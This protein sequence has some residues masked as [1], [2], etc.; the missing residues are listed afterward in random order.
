MNPNEMARRLRHDLIKHLDIPAP[1]APLSDAA[2]QVLARRLFDSGTGMCKTASILGFKLRHDPDWEPI[3]D[4]KL[5]R[6]EALCAKFETN[7]D[8]IVVRLK[9]GKSLTNDEIQQLHDIVAAVEDFETECKRISI[10]DDMPNLEE[11]AFD[12][13]GFG[14]NISKKTEHNSAF[15]IQSSPHDSPSPE[16]LHVLVVDDHLMLI[17]RLQ[18]NV[19]FI[20]RF[21]WATLC[22]RQISC[23]ACNARESCPLRRARNAHEA[24][25]AL[26][27]S[28]RQNR[29]ID[30]ILMDIRFDA[31][32]PEELL[33][34]SE[35]P[36]LQ[37]PERIK[38]LQG[39]IIAR[40]LR[41]FPDFARIPIVLM[42]D[43]SRL[44]DGANSLL[45]NMSGLQFVDDEDSLDAL[46]ARIESIVKLEREVRVEQGY[47]WG[48]SQSI[49][50]ARQQIEIMSQGPRTMLITGPSGSG[51]SSLVEKIIY[52]MSKRSPLVTLDLSAVPETLIESELFGHVKGAY[53][54]ASSDRM[55]LI[56]EADGGILFLDEIGNLSPEIQQKLLIFLQDKVVRR[57]GAP[58]QSARR[59]DVKVIVATCHDLDKDVKEGR[60]RFDL[61]MRFA[62]AMRIELP[63]LRDR[64]IDLPDFVEMLVHKTLN[65]SDMKP[66]LDSFKERSHTQGNIRVD[67]NRNYDKLPDNCACVRFKPA[68]RELFMSYNWP[69]NTRELESILDMLLLKAL[70]DLYVAH[71]PS[72]IIEI[73]PYYALTLLGEIEKTSIAPQAIGIQ[74]S[75]VQAPQGFDIGVC[76]DFAQLRQTLERRYLS[77]IYESCNGDLA[78]MGAKLFGNDGDDVK[79]KIAIRMNQLGLSLRQMKK[80]VHNAI[81]HDRE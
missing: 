73:D 6:V 35:D 1:G 8:D 13:F 43:K 46:A 54:G 20:R 4:D 61:Y 64:R 10:V 12:F 63:P 56:E 75:V 34:L 72:R 51:K 66:Y 53:S 27:R 71:S 40:Y 47:F 69:G 74:N 44:P 9:T 19:S 52:P 37:S 76:A 7:R 62:P 42:T 81:S 80:R 41:Q 49:R 57:V 29:K 15:P 79:H 50:S 23:L 60:F 70:Y 67:F 58:F 45:Q 65:S 78:Q 11:S 68:T 17:D 77:M 33:S 39:L 18:A 21:T 31:L 55:G 36:S 5:D 22:D 24:I 3:L 48:A 2:A 16:K 32:P 30:A 38:S 28:K 59:V 26:Q 14:S 25:E